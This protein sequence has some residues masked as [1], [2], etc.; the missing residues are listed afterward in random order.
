[1][2]GFGLGLPVVERARDTDGGRGGMREFK[3]HRHQLQAGRG[4]I[5]MVV[6]V[7]HGWCLVRM[8]VFWLVRLSNPNRY[9]VP[10]NPGEPWGITLPPDF[11]ARFA[12][13]VPDQADIWPRFFRVVA[14]NTLVAATL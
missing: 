10:E 5:V 3:P 6:I 4:D 11:T 13:S 12:A 1:M 7:F 2:K 8:I 14:G 9:D